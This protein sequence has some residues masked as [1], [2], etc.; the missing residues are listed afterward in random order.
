[1]FDFLDKM[2][3]ELKSLFKRIIL[4]TRRFFCKHYYVVQSGAFSFTITRLVK[5]KKCGLRKERE[6]YMEVHEK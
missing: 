2:K 1:M 5:C 3:Y 4:N 6:S